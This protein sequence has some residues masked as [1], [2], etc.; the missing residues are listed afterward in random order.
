M[1]LIES[2]KKLLCPKQFEK[3]YTTPWS[4]QGIDEMPIRRHS[5][6]ATI[7]SLDKWLAVVQK[8]VMLVFTCFKITFTRNLWQ[9]IKG[10]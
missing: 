2:S 3:I 8:A 4:I 10:P 1:T 6:A 7:E 5:P 9:H